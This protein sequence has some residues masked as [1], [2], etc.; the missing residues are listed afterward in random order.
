MPKSKNKFAP[1]FYGLAVIT[2]NIVLQKFFSY[3]NLFLVDI[4]PN[5]TN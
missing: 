1:D 2:E 4:F 5:L 3:F